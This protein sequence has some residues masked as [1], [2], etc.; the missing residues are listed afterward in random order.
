MFD[1]AFNQCPRHVR[2]GVA[3][4]R[5]SCVRS[6]VQLRVVSFEVDEVCHETWNGIENGSKYGF[7]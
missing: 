4:T 6:G 7:P 1:L 2:R 3:R 5:G